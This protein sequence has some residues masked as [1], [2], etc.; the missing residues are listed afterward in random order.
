MFT[1][2]AETHGV[3]I[4]TTWS[5]CTV[6]RAGRRG[7]HVLSVADALAQF[8]VRYPFVDTQAAELFAR[9]G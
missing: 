4:T 7:T 9:S 8:R 2:Y 1:D 5:P 6:D 3:P